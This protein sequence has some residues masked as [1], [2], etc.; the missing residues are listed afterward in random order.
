M[1]LSLLACLLPTLAMASPRLNEIQAL[2]SHN[3]YHL[4]PPPALLGTLK[5]FNKNAEAWNYSHPPLAKQLDLGIRQF[6]L[7]IFLDEKG[8]LFADPL[9]L[10]LAK[11]RNTKLPP[12]DPDGLWK[13]PGTKVLHVPDVDCWS[14]TPL[15]TGGLAEMLAW[16]DKHPRHLPVMILLECKDQPQPPLPTKPET[17]TRERLL[18]LEKEILSVIPASRILRPDD[19]RGT[20]ATLREAVMKSGWPEV[21]SLRGK[22]IFCL[23]NTDVIRKRYLEENPS[24][25]GRLIFASAPEEDHPAAG[26][27]KCNDPVREFDKIQRLV[28]AGFLVRTR[29]NVN[30]PSDKMRDKA[31]ASGA[32]WVSTDYFTGADKISFERNRLVR[33][34]PVL[35]KDG[36]KLEP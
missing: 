36:E 17:F 34:N 8:G 2:G 20:S 7:D 21:D 30:K 27:F 5:T 10:K 13:K 9:G 25:E 35:E 16:S 29:A 6:E 23:D 11:L 1:R 15:L 31:F 32:Q 22:F 33:G 4:A 18:G 28:K 24:L 19:V 14:N 3:S 12:H 26:W